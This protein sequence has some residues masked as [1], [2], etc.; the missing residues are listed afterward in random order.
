MKNIESILYTT[1]WM[2][3]VNMNSDS[4]SF[5]IQINN[6]FN[7]KDFICVY[8]SKTIIFNDKMLFYFMTRS[9]CFI[10]TVKKKFPSMII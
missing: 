9:P 2:I 1:K 3:I 7:L 5:I 8:K 10:H 6:I 4:I